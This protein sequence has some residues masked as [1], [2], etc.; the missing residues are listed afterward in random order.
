[1]ELYCAGIPHVCGFSPQLVSLFT[2]Q[3]LSHLLPEAVRL[4][5][6]KR[7]SHILTPP[8]CVVPYRC[9]SQKPVA[10]EMNGAAVRI[11]SALRSWSL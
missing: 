10:R 11:G 7:R 1:M 3:R 9:P 8:T 6:K 4:N 2:A 5:L